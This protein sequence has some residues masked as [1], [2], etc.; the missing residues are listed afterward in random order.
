MCIRDRYTEAHDNKTVFDKIKELHPNEDD[1]TTLKRQR[2]ATV[3]PLLSQGRPF[4]HAGQEF[5]RTKGGNENSYNAPAEVNE[6]DWKRAEEYKDNIEYIK[7]VIAIRKNEP[8]F[9][10]E[11][12]DQVD[13]RVKKIVASDGLIAYSLSQGAKNL[14]I[15]HNREDSAKEFNLPNGKYKVL[16]KADK[17]NHKG[18]ATIEIKDGK[19]AVDPMSTLMLE[20]LSNDEKPSEETPQQPGEDKPEEETPQKPGK[21]DPEK[22][23]PGK[24]EPEKEKPSKSKKDRD[25]DYYWVYYNLRANNFKGLGK[26][27]DQNPRLKRNYDALKKAY[28]KNL[29]TSKAARYL[30][31]KYPET[32]KPVRH[33]LE[34]LLERSE[35]LR[36]EAYELLKKLE[37]CYDY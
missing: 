3:I 22:E 23:K 20:N 33:E 28:N 9:H 18:L 5:A 30:L 19:I 15:G 34:K 13:A 1:A 32:V 4:I 25:D 11:S 17:A 27:C 8:L 31:D 14:Y 35:I 7:E 6:L 16:I 2:L 29:I 37:N 24:K 26:T 21:K 12:F 36:K 10:S